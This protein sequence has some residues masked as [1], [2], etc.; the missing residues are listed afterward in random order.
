MEFGIIITLLIFILIIAW[1][2]LPFAIFGI[3]SILR[4]ILFELK[5]LNRKEKLNYNS[6][7]TDFPKR[8]KIESKMKLKKCPNCD[9]YQDEKILECLVCSY[10][11]RNVEII[12][13]KIK[14]C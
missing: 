2:V 1:I 12:K 6:T 14:R 11:L 5:E 7:L 4:E 13:S 8:K 10:D 9:S 3:K